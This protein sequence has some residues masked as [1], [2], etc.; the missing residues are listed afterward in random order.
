MRE[1]R[2]QQSH[3]LLGDGL[4]LLCGGLLPRPVTGLVNE[5]DVRVGGIPD[6]ATS[7][8]PHGDDG[9]AGAS[10]LPAPACVGPRGDCLHPVALGDDQTGGHGQCPLQDRVGGVG[11]DGGG[12]FRVDAVQAV[13]Q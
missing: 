8:A 5:E 9:V 11:E 13:R 7:Q 3:D 2:G 10:G 4:G 12:A 6:L 1:R